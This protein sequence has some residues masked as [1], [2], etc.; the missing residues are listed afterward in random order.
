MICLRVGGYV[1]T[2]STSQSGR[3]RDQLAPPTDYEARSQT[4]DT[5]RRK[6]GSM[7]DGR[8][9]VPARPAPTPPSMRVC[10]SIHSVLF[11]ESAHT[12]RRCYARLLH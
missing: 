10:G 6:A 12:Q 7:R 5:G 3:G 9:Y 2:F 4:L 1:S 8:G 11:A